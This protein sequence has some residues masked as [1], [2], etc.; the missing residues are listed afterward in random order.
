MKV[1]NPNHKILEHGDNP[2]KHIESIGRICYK[3]EN[4]ITEVS[5]KPFVDRLV[6]SRHYAMIEHFRF[7]VELDIISYNTI[8][9]N[10]HRQYIRFT[11]DSKFII[12]ASARG[13]NDLFIIAEGATRR[14]LSA[15][16]RS[17]ANEYNCDSLFNCGYDVEHAW[18]DVHVITD[19]SK[20]SGYEYNEHA[21]YSVHIIC[22]RGVSH[23]LVRHRD[24]S[25]AQEST[26]YCN[27][28]KGKYGNEITVIEPYFWKEDSEQ[29][30]L[31]WKSC[32]YLEEMYMQ[33]INSGSTP[34]E[35]RS[36]LPNSLKTEIVI[37]A[38][39]YEWRHIFNLRVLG[40]TGAPHPQMKEVMEPVYEEMKERGIM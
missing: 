14:V 13:L 37:T 35:A 15:I 11:D 16:I 22:D 8:A 30:Q 36:I 18:G 7:I 34:Q 9:I 40:I 21:W 32:A 2:Y 26:R 20:L 3:S 6:K 4:S 29:Y 28:S 33:L 27:Y 25:F 38:P 17:I 23:E 24:A 5:A 12:S 39:V 1:I 10:K 31:W 19:F